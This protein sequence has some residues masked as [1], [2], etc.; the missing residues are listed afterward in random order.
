MFRLPPQSQVI[1][2][3]KRRSH[4]LA[5]GYGSPSSP[6]SAAAAAAA[7]KG[8]SNKKVFFSFL[9]LFLAVLSAPHMCSAPPLLQPV[10]DAD[11]D[12]I[13]DG[14]EVE[15]PVSQTQREFSSRQAKKPL[16]QQFVLKSPQNPRPS[17]KLPEWSVGHTRRGSPGGLLSPPSQKVFTMA[18]EADDEFVEGTQ[19]MATDEDETPPLPASKL[20]A[21]RVPQRED[22]IEVDQSDEEERGMSQR[23]QTPAQNHHLHPQAERPPPSFIFSARVPWM[24]GPTPAVLMTPLPSP[25]SVPTKTPLRDSA[26]AV[27]PRWQAPSLQNLAALDRIASSSGKGL[28]GGDGDGGAD[29]DLDISDIDAD[30][31]DL[32]PRKLVFTADGASPR[33]REVAVTDVLRGMRGAVAAPRAHRQREEDEIDSQ[34]SA[35]ADLSAPPRRRVPLRRGMTVESI[36]ED[37]SPDSEERR[38]FHVG[39]NWRGVASDEDIDEVLADAFSDAA[40]P[41]KSGGALRE[42]I[43]E[44]SESQE[45]HAVVKRQRV[46]GEEHTTAKAAAAFSPQFRLADDVPVLRAPFKPGDGSPQKRRRKAR[47]SYSEMLRS[48][49]AFQRG[50]TTAWQNAIDAGTGR[51]EFSRYIIEVLRREDTTITATSTLIPQGSTR[52][53]G[54]PPQAT[55]C[56]SDPDDQFDFAEGATVRV[57]PPFAQVAGQG[58]VPT[59]FC[60]LF[61]IEE[62]HLGTQAPAPAHPPRRPNNLFVTTLQFGSLALHSHTIVS[63]NEIAGA[64]STTLPS[65]ATSA[66]QIVPQSST[67]HPQAPED[68]SSDDEFSMRDLTQVPNAGRP[69]NDPLVTVLN[70]LQVPCLPQTPV[71]LVGLVQ[72]VCSTPDVPLAPS[73]SSLNRRKGAIPPPQPQPPTRNL[74]WSVIFQGQ[75]GATFVLRLAEPIPES[76]ELKNLLGSGEGRPVLLQNVMITKKYVVRTGSALHS[77]IESFARSPATE[78]DATPSHVVFELENTPESRIAPC[79][80]QQAEG[81]GEYVAPAVINLQQLVEGGAAEEARVSLVA[82]VLSV[83]SEFVVVRDASLQSDESVKVELRMEGEQVVEAAGHVVFLKDLLFREGWLVLDTMSVI[84]RLAP[85]PGWESQDEAQFLAR[86]RESNFFSSAVEVSRERFDLLSSRTL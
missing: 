74:L 1:S 82:E 55:I 65:I 14:G 11:A 71:S 23:R 42:D 76:A 18:A 44:E 33:E 85:H 38:E 29:S 73:H 81:L 47:G 69:H 16:V 10:E 49:L 19:V 28:S 54:D 84:R 24:G 66:A 26:G 86:L 59:I 5:S 9:L 50:K 72:R 36:E 3:H 78:G 20:R 75:A 57:F 80:P 39:K 41:L 13:E 43:D 63:R 30:F 15:E 2:V 8:F 62:H 60:R 67:A 17:P 6:T 53:A 31:D 45:I 32:V 46:G 34:S 83:G 40:T 51:L 61:S 52:A 7:G 56:F 68:S 70:T 25:P 58:G 21:R 48:M 27:R 79:T 12:N 37:L 35:S 64:L 77:M 4:P 22:D